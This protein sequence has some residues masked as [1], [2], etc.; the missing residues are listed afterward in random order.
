VTKIYC[1]AV[2]VQV[3]DPASL[4]P[5]DAAEELWEDLDRRGGWDVLTVSALWIG[6]IRE[7]HKLTLTR[8]DLPR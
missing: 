5:E 3:E 4:T 6:G 2:T 7:G 8:R 1:L